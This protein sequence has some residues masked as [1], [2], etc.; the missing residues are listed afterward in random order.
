MSA[1]TP[2]GDLSALTAGELIDGFRRRQFSPVEALAAIS[3]RI[4]AVEDRVHAFVATDLER[5]RDA[6]EASTRAYATGTAGALEGVP[7]AIKDTF[8]VAGL[9]T[10]CGSPIFRDDV[11]EVDSTVVRRL[12]SAGAVIVGKTLTHEFAWG[13]TAV[14]E[15]FPA[16]RNPWNPRRVA[17]GSSGGSAVALACHEVPLA[18]GTDT[19]GSIRVPSAFCGV[20]GIKPTQGRVSLA[21]SFPL[22][23]SMDH[24]G[25]M[26]RTPADLR[27]FLAA[28]AGVDPADPSTVDQPIGFGARR[29][30]L[31]G[32]RVGICADLM[33]VRLAKDVERVWK[34]AQATFESLGAELVDVRCPSAESIFATFATI[35]LAEALY[36]HQAAGLYPRLRHRYGAD[37][38]GRLDAAA[39]V[40]LSEYL[41]AS[42]QRVR[43]A[44]DMNVVF[45]SV[46]VLLTPVSAGSPVE[47]GSETV[48]HLGVTMTFRD[49]VMPYTVPQ[50]LTGLPTCSVRAG[51][52]D[53]GIPVG[54][55]V[56]GPAW[57]E[58]LILDVTAGFFDATPD[59]Q[60]PAPAG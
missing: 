35:Q 22:T 58:A 6:A 24:S 52:D 18:L 46:D 3:E 19:G 28:I 32:L 9:A 54:V 8:D 31:R 12:R 13:I 23:R 49:L 4:S 50:D 57:S 33:L 34:T 20:T 48:E 27:S 14:N 7:V 1:I 42:V 30:D 2:N 26:A 53:L 5:A 36:V 15:H 37:V 29:A 60:A 56:T 45:E 39:A 21:G 11:K 55:Q 43:I 47:Y 40:T 59:V 38:L 16:C 10:T 25:P 44:A 17:G 41:A 51:F